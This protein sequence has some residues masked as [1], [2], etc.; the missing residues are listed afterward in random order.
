MASA[1]YVAGVG[2]A[3]CTTF[4][5]ALGLS[6]QKLGHSDTQRRNAE[7]A[8]APGGPQGKPYKVVRNVKW[9]AGLALMG[10]AS[11]LSLAV[12]ALVGQSVASAF[13]AITIVYNMALARIFLKER[14]DR[15]AVLV[16]VVMVAGT[17]LVV[18]FGS[19]GANTDSFLS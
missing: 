11:L 19:Q 5:N 4:M 7:R 14:V 9:L 12:F 17:V 13:A 16:A 6:L 18:V 3:L 8:R 15:I 1:K 10:A 2:I